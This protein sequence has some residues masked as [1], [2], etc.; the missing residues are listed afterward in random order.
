MSLLYRYQKE[1]KV[2]QRCATFK[3]FVVR[4]IRDIVDSIMDI[5]LGVSDC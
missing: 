1:M 5:V 3:K 2:T 4:V